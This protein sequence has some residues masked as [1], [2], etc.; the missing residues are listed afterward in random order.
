MRSRATTDPGR[1]ASLKQAEYQLKQAR[2]TLAAAER[3]WQLALGLPATSKVNLVPENPYFQQIKEELAKLA[4]DWEDD[5][6]LM[7][8]LSANHYQLAAHRRDQQQVREEWEWKQAERK[9]EI[10]AGGTY[11]YPE[12][13]WQINLNLNY[14]LWDGGK[15]RLEEGRTPSLT[16][17][18]RT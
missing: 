12:H 11:N 15:K 16:A 3:E 2:N 13:K 9:P 8:V 7:K 5:E 10:T 18:A 17:F 1:E 14:K 6:W 4:F